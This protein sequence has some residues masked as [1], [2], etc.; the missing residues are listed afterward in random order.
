MEKAISNDSLNLKI[1]N[2][3]Y[4]CKLKESHFAIVEEIHL[5]KSNSLIKS[6]QKIY[7]SRELMYMFLGSLIEH[8]NKD[9]DNAVDVIKNLRNVPE[10]ASKLFSPSLIKEFDVIIKLN[11]AA[12][13]TKSTIEH[14][15]EN[16]EG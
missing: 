5:L 13:I 15:G 11:D 4:G 8:R 1:F 3:T 12:L 7:D 14:Y 16:L 10:K 2:L 9:I 6:T